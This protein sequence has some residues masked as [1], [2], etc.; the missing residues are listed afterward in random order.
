MSAR[1][2]QLRDRLAEHWAEPKIRLIVIAVVVIPSIAFVAFGAIRASKLAPAGLTQNPVVIINQLSPRT[3]LF[4]D[5]LRAEIEVVTNSR[6]IDP[7]SVSLTATFRPYRIVG[8]PI[9][10]RSRRENLA[11]FKTTYLLQCLT[12]G[13]LP[14]AQGGALK[15]APV[16]ISYRQGGRTVSVTRAWPGLRVFSRLTPSDLKTPVLRSTP[17]RS[18]PASFRLPSWVLETIL[19]ATAIV[20]ALVGAVLVTGAFWPRRF[21]SLRRWRELSPLEQALAQLEAAATIENDEVRR[22]VL[23]Q[24]ARR[25]EELNLESLGDETRLLAWGAEAPQPA[26]MSALGERVRRSLNGGGPRQ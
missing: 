20:L 23:E 6:R 14:P 4:G 11:L 26:Q 22:R 16:R 24:L 1:I 13:C 18:A 17:P 21:Y 3:A 8:E 10:E 19:A 9:V 2:R 7:D 12:P 5:Q 15:L 25:L